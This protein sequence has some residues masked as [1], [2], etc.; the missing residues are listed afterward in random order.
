MPLVIVGRLGRTHGL[1]GSLFVDQL[2]LSPEELEAI[3]EF[4]WRGRDG[5]ERPL[6]LREARAMGHRIVVRFAGFGSKEDAQELVNGELRTERDRVPDAGPGQAYLFQLV[7]LRMVD[8][9]G[10]EIGVVKDVLRTGAHPVYVVAGEREILV[11]SAGPI[12]Q[13]VD[14][15]AGVITVELPEGLEEL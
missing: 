12:V 10:R 2:S 1:D 11:P 4:V 14:L 7:G 5:E 8:T 6:R 13:R 9:R 15:E 3:G